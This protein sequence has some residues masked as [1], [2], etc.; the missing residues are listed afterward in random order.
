LYRVERRTM[1]QAKTVAEYINGLDDWRGEAVS[2][3][4]R[5][6]KE[7]A[8]DAKE[9]IKWARPVYEESGPLC[10]IMAFKN[11]VNLGFWRG[12]DLPDD[13]GILEG[14]GEKMRHVKVSGLDDIQEDVLGDLIRAA[15][16]LNR[17]T[18]GS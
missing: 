4:H 7:A 2:I 16:A 14:S 3:L 13:A 12:V 10:Y 9:S 17:S 15:L 6:V 5:L 1:G 11:H 18:G 8:P